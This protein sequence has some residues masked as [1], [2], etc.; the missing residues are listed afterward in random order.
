[1]TQ[2]LFYT[3]VTL[4][5][6]DYIN[7]KKRIMK[8]MP[9][10]TYQALFKCFPWINSDWQIMNYVLSGS[11]YCHMPVIFANGETEAQSG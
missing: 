2:A 1:M 11:C 7:K 3:Y 4:Q 6:N 8:I 5:Q 9:K 10:S